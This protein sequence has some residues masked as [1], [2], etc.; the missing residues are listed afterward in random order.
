MTTI[1]HRTLWGS[2]SPE[3]QSRRACVRA[4]E[5]EREKASGFDGG[6]GEKRQVETVKAFLQQSSPHT[7]PP[8]KKKKLPREHSFPGGL[9]FSCSVEISQSVPRFEHASE[10]HSRGHSPR[11]RGEFCRGDNVKAASRASAAAESDSTTTICPL[12]CRHRRRSFLSCPCAAPAL[13]LSSSPN[14]S[15]AHWWFLVSARN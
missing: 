3:R 7:P 12:P 15:E 1:C 13:G 10:T 9:F 8:Q 6:S 11:A 2:W 4:P 5:R 14:R